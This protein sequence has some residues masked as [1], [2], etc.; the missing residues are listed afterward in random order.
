[1][2]S[3]WEK[4][5][6]PRWQKK[7]L[8]ILERDRWACVRCG[9]TTTTLNVHHGYYERGLDPWDYGDY[10]LWT[11]CEPCHEKAQAELS[12][13]HASLGILKPTEE[14]LVTAC[15]LIQKVHE[16]GP[17]Y[18]GRYAGT[19][20]AD[21]VEHFLIAIE[22]GV[23]VEQVRAIHDKYY[24]SDTLDVSEYLNV[25]EDLTALIQQKRRERGEAVDG[26]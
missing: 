13:A 26:E 6:D 5:R 17:N 11:L 4:L 22:L 3:Y 2:S 24:S 7:R 8:Q 10:S 9:D 14:L 15:S 1:M 20:S 21:I 12:I 23:P 18:L 19:Y 25:R 16:W